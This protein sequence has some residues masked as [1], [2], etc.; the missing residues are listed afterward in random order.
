[1]TELDLVVLVSGFIFF[2]GIICLLLERNIIK[3]LISLEI[4]LISAMLNFC[5]S[6]STKGLWFGYYACIS[7]VVIG[8]LTFCVVF[9][10]C[11]FEF[12]NCNNMFSVD[13]E[14]INV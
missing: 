4:I 1:M 6:S 13:N 10:I 9:S 7:I 11:C 12:K 5:C 3:T 14:D 8:V 2:I